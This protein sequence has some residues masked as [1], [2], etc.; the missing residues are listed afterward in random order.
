MAQAKGAKSR[1]YRRLAGSEYEARGWIYM[2]RRT[3]K[4]QKARRKGPVGPVHAVRRTGGEFLSRP[5]GLEDRSPQ[6]VDSKRD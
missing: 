3:P 2:A 1:N 6:Q 4:G 5:S